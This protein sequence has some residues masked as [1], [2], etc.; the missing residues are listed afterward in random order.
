MIPPAA[1]RAE[2]VRNGPTATAVPG[3]ASGARS[4]SELEAVERVPQHDPPLV[5]QC[6]ALDGAERAVD[7]ARDGAHPTERQAQ[8]AGAVIEC[9]HLHR[10]A[11]PDAPL[12]TDYLAG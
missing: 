3:P 12:G 6:R 5:G 2:T 4:I 11:T 10:G 9:E 7:H 8:P 1:D